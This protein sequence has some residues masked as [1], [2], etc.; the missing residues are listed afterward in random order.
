MQRIQF[1]DRSDL[2]RQLIELEIRF[3]REK[4]ERID[5][6]EY[7]DRFPDEVQSIVQL[8]SM[9]KQTHHSDL[10]ISSD[11]QAQ[12]SL[13]PA[14]DAEQ[15]PLRLDGYELQ[16]RIG[17]GGMGVVYRGIDTR[18]G[19]TVA[20][21]ILPVHTAE[22]SQSA[23]ARFQI[24]AKAAAQ[25]DHPNV[26]RVYAIGV[27]KGMHYFV[28]QFIDGKDLASYIAAF[29]DLSQSESSKR[30]D[31]A[32]GSTA[33]VRSAI[34]KR[35]SSDSY[36]LNRFTRDGVFSVN[37]EFLCAFAR[38]G[39]EVANALGHA[40][41][42]G[43]VHRDIKPSNL[44][45]DGR[46]RAYVAD[47]GLARIQGEAELTKLGDVVGTWRY[48]SPEQAYA[49]RLVVDHRSDLFSLGATLYELLTLRHAFDGKT[50]TDILRQIAFEDPIPPRRIDASV[51][52]D[53]EIIVLKCLAKN[54]DERYQTADE[55]ANDLQAW[56]SDEPIKAR[57]PSLQQR[58]RKWARKHRVFVNTLAAASVITILAVIS[59]L[60]Y[61]VQTEAKSRKRIEGKNAQL[62][63]ALKQ[64]EGRRL[65]ALAS[66]ELQHDPG[67]SLAL[68]KEGVKR[69]ED[70]E[71]RTVLL[72]AFEANRE[73]AILSHRLAAE[74]RFSPDGS[75]IVTSGSSRLLLA[76]PEPARIFDARSGEL[77]AELKSDSAITS[78]VFSPD[79]ARVLAVS[80]PAGALRMSQQELAA[81]SPLV[82]DVKRGVEIA[83]LE[84]AF[85][86][87]ANPNSFC[88]TGETAKIV[89]PA[90][91]NTA[92]VYNTVG[93]VVSILRGHTDRVTYAGFS[94]D[95]TRIITL[96]DDQ[97]VRIWEPDS[98]AEI[99]KFDRW[100]D[101]VPG[102]TGVQLVQQ[103]ALSPDSNLLL[104]RSTD[105][106]VELWRLDHG[107]S[108][109]LGKG[110]DA[111]FS[112]DGEQIAIAN[113]KAIRIIDVHSLIER[114][115][116]HCER[117][118]G[119]FEFSPDGQ[120]IACVDGTNAFHVWDT[121]TGLKRGE[122]RGHD[123]PVDFVSFGPDSQRLVSASGDSTARL[124]YVDSG[125]ERL[126]F[127]EP[128]SSLVP[129][130]AT[131][132]HEQQVCL[133]VLPE[134]FSAIY[135][136]ETNTLQ[137]SKPGN[138]RSEIP[139]GLR[140]VTS[141]EN[142]VVVW[143][144]ASGNHLASFK[145]RVGTIQDAKRSAQ[146]EHVLVVC[147]D[148]P[149]WIW[150]WESEDK[151][152]R[153]N[154]GQ[155][156]I[157]ESCFR[158]DGSSVVVG[159]E[160]GVVRSVDTDSG[161]ELGRFQCGGSVRD[162][163]YGP[164]GKHLLV[165]SSESRGYVL[166]PDTMKVV[167]E[168]ASGDHRFSRGR[169][170]DGG[171][172]ILAWQLLAKSLTCWDAE[173]GSFVSEV[174]SPPGIFYVAVN[175]KGDKAAVSSKSQGL[176]I[177]DIESGNLRRLAS[178]QF[179]PV[180][181][182][183]D[184]QCVVATGYQAG[185]QLSGNSEA[186]DRPGLEV[187]EL[188]SRD[189]PLQKT[190]LQLGA[191]NWLRY[192]ERG[193]R[194][195]I[196]TRN[197]GMVA[198]DLVSQSRLGRVRGHAAPV[199]FAAYTPNGKHI[200]TCSQDGLVSLWDKVT[201]ELIQSVFEH[202]SPPTAAAIS[203][204]GSMLATADS[205]GSVV[206]WKL[207]DGQLQPSRRL[208]GFSSPVRGCSF[209]AFN[210]RLAVFDDRGDWKVWD[211]STGATVQYD[212]ERFGVAFAEFQPDGSKLLLVPKRNAKPRDYFVKV[213]SPQSNE[214][215]IDFER[216]PASVRFDPSGQSLVGVFADRVLLID[217]NNGNTL[218]RIGPGS[219]MRL[220]WLDHSKRVLMI[221]ERDT[222]SLW[223]PSGE[224]IVNL[225]SSAGY[226][227]AESA[228]RFA[229]GYAFLISAD[230][231]V[232]KVPFL[233]DE[234]MKASR[235]LSDEER[236]RFHLDVMQEVLQDGQL[237]R[238]TR[239]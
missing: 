17:R 111:A 143:D 207:D 65:V 235:A 221:D 34:T 175:S 20:I 176:S 198:Y 136:L 89:T 27:D 71:A 110:S 238:A 31:L 101:R 138:N 108:T 87:S 54:P 92:R 232:Q 163:C 122:Y 37:H 39:I 145:Q 10:T 182:V 33:R 119:Y 216:Y 68:A 212:V 4:G 239:E 41:Q 100:R 48:M 230:N 130:L 14:W 128:V 5:L 61:A 90:I 52:E 181:F 132:R 79:G 147:N 69:H 127:D 116:L 189:R 156:K 194:L 200:V 55:V 21:K 72:N 59:S 67:L 141:E 106:G 77:V 114:C 28:M 80:C 171:R 91:D 168:L 155:T 44:L 64:S 139:D 96:S 1:A 236:Q 30:R 228:Q 85:L 173:T 23:Q 227:F 56:L 217:P 11:N 167:T 183:S 179:G 153:I 137:V 180:V 22:I 88:P 222:I 196:G 115:K 188:G 49:K 24:E 129:V 104:T 105:V 134:N 150:N 190:S 152:L 185:K 123:Q 231:R 36:D 233:V 215:K 174:P 208:R 162:L 170:A 178:G 7:R 16:E 26:V 120:L 93:D 35:D 70:A 202:R 42:L 2:I 84:G 161:E 117:W 209:S 157:T 146:G 57:R 103:A 13:E 186:A 63:A 206:T 98:G 204:D 66:L 151:R 237:D 43:I 50:R 126:S 40:H 29:K 169:F 74:A 97:T 158:P 76:D 144:C 86:L 99:Q 51:P 184:D 177:W 3:R 226:A 197:F 109:S 133:S 83:T 60:A 159:D 6:Q 192:I 225:Q 205:Q 121:E 195:L 8:E 234:M 25:L 82:F 211:T 164:A 12:V 203:S 94:G 19:T 107:E 223:K 166:D 160:K 201:L 191:I 62:A 199:M 193:N 73:Y 15:Y 218:Q 140:M 224:P 154:D 113:G 165:I 112:P 38:L 149:S 187:W 131:D 32:R 95:G 46:G 142:E 214:L 210:S 102:R 220:C 125:R 81:N 78:A 45:I 135:E 58:T 229:K 172:K 9:L 219:Q 53:I 124:W 148:G 213:V 75:K 47:F 18:L 118:A